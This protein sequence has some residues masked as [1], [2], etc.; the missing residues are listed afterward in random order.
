MGFIIGCAVLA[1]FLI[2]FSGYML[3]QEG[4]SV[5]SGVVC[6]IG[7]LFFV[8]SLFFAYGEGRQSILE[9]N[10]EA[11]RAVLMDQKE[12]LEQRMSELNEE[13]LELEEK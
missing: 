12:Q 6:I 3:R 5:L 7:L 1:F 9:N 2:I 8:L 13:L 4:E 11:Q 10:P